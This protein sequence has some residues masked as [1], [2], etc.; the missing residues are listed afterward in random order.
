MDTSPSVAVCELPGGSDMPGTVVHAEALA[1]E[2][3]TGRGETVLPD[4]GAGVIADVNSIP[5]PAS[6]VEPGQ[7]IRLGA[8]G[9]LMAPALGIRTLKLFAQDQEI[10][11]AGNASG[12]SE[13]VPCDDGRFYAE[14]EGEY[15]VP[16]P[17]PP[18]IEVCAV[19]T[20]FD[21]HEGRGCIEFFTQ[22]VWTGTIQLDLFKDYLA[23][24]AEVPKETCADAWDVH[25]TFT[26]A[27]DGS[28]AG[29]A[30]AALI[31]GPECTFDIP[32][33]ATRADFTV[34]GRAS[35][36]RFELAFALTGI[37]E[38]GDFAGLLGAMSSPFVVARIGTDRAEGPIAFETT[39]GGP[40]PVTVQGQVSLTCPLC[41]AEGA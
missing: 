36:D 33:N 4:M 41:A 7:R 12:S 31:A 34:S 2:G 21:D 29:R 40:F 19:A 20:T 8:I 35:S 37:D 18:V 10:G 25:V 26:V 14:L 13:P 1:G 22:H 23:E 5:P 6:R 32:G 3:S 15:T 24:Q 39:D 17:A 30:R 16:D 11:S 38:P 28:V 9:M 27:D